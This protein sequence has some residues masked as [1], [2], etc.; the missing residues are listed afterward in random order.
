MRGAPA[1]VVNEAAPTYKFKVDADKKKRCE[2][3]GQDGRRQERQDEL[4]GQNGR[5][6]ER[7][8]QEESASHR[9]GWRASGTQR[10]VAHAPRALAS[11]APAQRNQGSFLSRLTQKARRLRSRI[12]SRPGHIVGGT[13]VSNPF[14]NRITT[15]G[16]RLVDDMVTRGTTA[17]LRSWLLGKGPTSVF[18]RESLFHA[19]NIWKSKV[20]WA[21]GDF[22]LATSGG[23]PYAM[24]F[25]CVGMCKSS[26][27]L[28]SYILPKHSATS[29]TCLSQVLTCPTI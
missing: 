8:G 25:L 18:S 23:Q 27:K 13:N 21:G 17:A 6:Q 10:A 12:D 26:S 22:D 16:R 14:L 28:Y 2:H 11:A 20:A 7:R 3:Q 24:W 29:F 5:R 15:G 1:I 9:R 4:P 19:G